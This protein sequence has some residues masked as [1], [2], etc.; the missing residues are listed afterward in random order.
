MLFPVYLSKY[1]DRESV[2][3]FSESLAVKMHL[4]QIDY[5]FFCSVLFEFIVSKLIEIKQN[6]LT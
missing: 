2:Q 4:Q 3:N 5:L 6:K 1:T